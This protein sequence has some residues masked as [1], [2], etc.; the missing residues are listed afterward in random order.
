M[1]LLLFTTV[2]VH[3]AASVMLVG[4]CALLLLA[5]R[6]DRPTARRW[7]ATVVAWARLLV[8][9]ALVSGIV[10]LLART[11]VFEGRAQAALEPRAV[12]HAVVDTRPGLIWPARHGLLL[13]LAA[14]LPIRAGLADRASWLAPRGEALLPGLV[15]LGPGS[16]SRPR[17]EE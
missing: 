2:W 12:W 16:G 4:A 15:A 3:L 10:G 11:A 14:F 7:E 13:V 8:L 17:S 6:S 1:R 5:G 9:L